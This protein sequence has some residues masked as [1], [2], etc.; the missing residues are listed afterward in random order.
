MKIKPNDTYNI[1][2]SKYNPM[3]INLL[4]LSIP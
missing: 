3:K 2:T 1:L 4:N